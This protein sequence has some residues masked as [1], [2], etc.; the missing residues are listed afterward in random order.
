ME[1]RYLVNKQNVDNSNFVRS[2]SLTSAGNDGQFDKRYSIILLSQH[3]STTGAPFIQVVVLKI[4]GKLTTAY[5]YLQESESMCKYLQ[6]A[7][8]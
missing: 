2:V 1:K 5:I 7:N 6:K 8:V 3:V 4:F